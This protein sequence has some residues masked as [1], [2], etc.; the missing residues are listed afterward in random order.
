[1]TAQE[2][3]ANWSSLLI[4]AL[5]AMSDD[6]LLARSLLAIRLYK[7]DRGNNRLYDEAHYCSVE[8]KSPA[9]REGIWKEALAMWQEEWKR[10]VA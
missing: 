7:R 2:E 8:C 9:R 10:G 6:E 1:M 4:A 5:K 3:E